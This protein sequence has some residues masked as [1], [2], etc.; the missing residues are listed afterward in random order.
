MHAPNP[1]AVPLPC[2]RFAWGPPVF[3]TIGVLNPSYRGGMASF[4][5]FLFVF[6]GYDMK[7]ALVEA[8]TAPAYRSFSLIGSRAQHFSA[9][10]GYYSARIYK[11]FRG[12]RWHWNAF[13]VRPATDE[14]LESSNSDH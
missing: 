12:V 10:G 4:A 5:V 9:F 8:G 14:R 3:A 11:A 1:R 7:K 2:G 6:M 13:M